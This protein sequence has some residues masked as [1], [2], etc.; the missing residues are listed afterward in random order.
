MPTAQ[1]SGTA[2]DKVPV[3]K[4]R[5]SSRLK[6]SKATFDPSDVP[7]HDL[8]SGAAASTNQP[9]ESS[10][11]PAELD[12]TSPTRSDVDEVSIQP[13]E[14]VQPIERIQPAEHKSAESYS[15]L[16]LYQKW[17]ASC[18]RVSLMKSTLASSKRELK[19]LQKEKRLT[20]RELELC[21]QDKGKL[22]KLT[23]E[24]SVAS[25]A[26]SSLEEEVAFLTS[27][28]RRIATAHKNEITHVINDRKFKLET[29]QLAAQR[30]LNEEKLKVK[31][32]DLTI[33]ALK[34][35]IDRLGEVISGQA[36]KCTNY[37]E[38]TACAVKANIQMQVC[39]DK[40]RVR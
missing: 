19:D 22:E 16:S 39:K 7:T 8:I 21:K 20:V 28:K 38:L 5:K 29:A 9:A 6:R 3:P 15:K 18:A 26:K 34:E 35:K 24:L 13:I 10:N 36:K 32:Q 40:A 11:Q 30:V 37:D 2:A 23:Y 25:V 27:E 33:T 1:P 31:E 17:T 12:L 14:S 4:P